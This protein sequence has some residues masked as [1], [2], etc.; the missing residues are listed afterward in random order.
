[1]G[2]SRRQSRGGD[3][4]AVN[5]RGAGGSN[6]MNCGSAS[7][8]DASFDSSVRDCAGVPASRDVPTS[9]QQ[10]LDI[11]AGWP[12]SCCFAS[13]TGCRSWANSDPPVPARRPAMRANT[14]SFVR[15]PVTTLRSSAAPVPTN[16]CGKYWANLSLLAAA[17]YRKPGKTLVAAGNPPLSGTVSFRSSTTRTAVWASAANNG[18]DTEVAV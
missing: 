7:V 12:Q 18:D 4:R 10:Q 8:T 17:G 13:Q 16:G 15:R 1:M 14:T 2:R 3:V 9:P 5:V 11:L 6:W